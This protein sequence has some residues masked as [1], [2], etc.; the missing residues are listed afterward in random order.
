[1]NRLCP[2]AATGA[3]TLLLTACPPLAAAGT[4]A[5]RSYL[6]RVVAALDAMERDMPAITAAAELAAERYVNHPQGTLGVLGDPG[7]FREATDRSGGIMRVFG[8]AHAAGDKGIMLFCLSERGW[9][10]DIKQAKYFS[11]TGSMIIAFGRRQLLDRAREAGCPMAAALDLHVPGDGTWADGSLPVDRPARLAALWLW[12]GEFVAACTRRGR[13]PPMYLGYAVPGGRERAAKFGRHVRFHD[14]TPAAV[15]A[16][17]VA[18]AYLAALRRDLRAVADHEM[19]EIVRTADLALE[20]R[21]AGR[22]VYAFLHGHAVHCSLGGPADPG[23]FTQA[24]RDWV[25]LKDEI[26][27][28]GG[29]FMF[30]LGF[31][32]PFDGDWFKELAPRLR[33]DGVRLAI[34]VTDYKHEAISAIPSGEP[35]INQHWGFGDAV[36]ELPG[37]DVKILPTSAVIAE[38]ILWMVQAEMHTRAVSRELDRAGRLPAKNA[39]AVAY[40]F[41]ADPARQDWSPS[42]GW[43]PPRGDDSDQRQPAVCPFEEVEEVYEFDPFKEYGIPGHAELVRFFEDWYQKSQAGSPEQVITG[44]RYVTLVSAAIEI[45]GWDML[46][47]AA[48]DQERFARVLERLGEYSIRHAEA[49]AETSIEAYIQHDDMVW[50]SG[51][52]MD[53]AFYRSVIFPLYRRMWEPLRK[54]GKKVLFCSDG[55]FTMFMHDLAAAG[56][57]GFIF[58][59]S[60]DFDWIVDHFGKTHCLVGSKVDCRT[61]AFKPWANV[62]AEIDATLARAKDCAGLMW[63]VGNHIPANVSDEMC[64][65]YMNYLRANWK[66]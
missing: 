51:P 44:G 4:T 14:E 18:R 54:A 11:G 19:D 53:P 34:S 42:V 59:P 66:R 39:A 62:K 21:D 33:R 48:A 46:L 56:A 7:F 31:D 37:Y 2:L 32:Q 24:N 8:G 6:E 28:H 40:R 61:M 5:A 36:V 57:E 52:F 63:A 9:D 13:M 27:L 45:F 58:E 20:A 3:L 12:T 41:D 43:I 10:Q 17:R 65:R 47:M 22:G 25:D 26:E 29:D 23:Y 38:T 16:G 15:P 55:T 50:T 30:C 35:F 1:M 49:W 64:D 60:N